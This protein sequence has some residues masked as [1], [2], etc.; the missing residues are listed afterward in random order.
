M[1][2]CTVGSRILFFFKPELFPALHGENKINI[3]PEIIAYRIFPIAAF[4]ATSLI[5]ANTAYIYLSVA[6]V[7]M[8]KASIPVITMFIM[9]CFKLEDPT[10]CTFHDSLQSIISSAP[11][12]RPP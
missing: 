12:P 3:T 1:F 11:L 9:F 5:L 10:V 6:Y 4:F 8:I 7:Q 2:L